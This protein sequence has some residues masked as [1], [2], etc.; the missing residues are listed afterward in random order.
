MGELSSGLDQNAGY[1][2]TL[3]R[4]YQFMSELFGA[5]HQPDRNPL[6]RGTPKPE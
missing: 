4:N 6:L 1:Y 3:R 5:M 2:Q